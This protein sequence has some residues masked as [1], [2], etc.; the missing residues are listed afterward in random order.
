MSL[1]E[2]SARYDKA[3]EVY[4]SLF[5]GGDPAF[6]VHTLEGVLPPEDYQSLQEVM[7]DVQELRR[8]LWE[9]IVAMTE[10]P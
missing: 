9:I 7:G 6:Y 4:T 1:E 10:D 3:N 5:R 8:R 2:L